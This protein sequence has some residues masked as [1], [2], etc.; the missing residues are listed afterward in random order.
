MIRAYKSYGLQQE[1][2]AMDSGKP[3]SSWVAGVSVAPR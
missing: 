3:Q 1:R 2:K